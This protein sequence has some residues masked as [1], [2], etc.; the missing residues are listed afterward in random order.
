MQVVHL[1]TNILIGVTDPTS[2]IR[3]D[4]QH[5]LSQG[6]Q[7]G[8]SAMAWSEFRCGPASPELIE[9]WQRLLDN[10]ILPVNQTLAELAAELFNQTGRRSRSLPDCLIAATAID[11]GAQL[12]TMNRNDFEPFTKFGLVLV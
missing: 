11:A 9:A 3:I 2:T 12:A 4:L 7:I 1:D 6:V 10:R 5:W 8:V